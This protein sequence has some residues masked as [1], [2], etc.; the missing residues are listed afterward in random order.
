MSTPVDSKESDELKC[1]CGL[2][3]KLRVSKTPRNPFR[4]FYNCSKGIHDQCGYFHWADES[5]ATGDRQTDE[6]NLIRNECIQL[7][8]RMG[9][10]EEEHEDEKTIW[11]E[12][13]SAL[14]SQLSTVQ[15]EL[16]EMKKRI[17]MANE[18]DL[19]P[20]VD[21]FSKSDDEADDAIIIHTL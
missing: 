19:M 18:S 1:T 17:K 6:L 10:I 13:K 16:D 11:N 9:E 12:E 5:A 21:K 4:L 8:R 15:A 3:A 2:P 7:Q 20:P 14:M